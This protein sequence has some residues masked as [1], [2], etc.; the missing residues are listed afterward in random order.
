MNVKEQLALA[1]YPSTGSITK[2]RDHQQLHELVLK[3]TSFLDGVSGDCLSVRLYSIV[4]D[5]TSLPICAAEGCGKEVR[6]T[7]NKEKDKGQ[8]GTFVFSEFCSMSCVRNSEEVRLRREATIEEK[9]GGHHMQTDEVKN[10]QQQTMVERYGV[11][12]PSQIPEFLN[13]R[14]TKIEEN[15][16]APD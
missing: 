5:I 4:N 16:K 2:K 10:K 9:F 1:G 13:K 8:Y 15:K 3:E 7:R 11:T 14:N 6:V 12:H